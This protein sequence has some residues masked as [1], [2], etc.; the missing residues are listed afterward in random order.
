[1][2]TIAMHV[3]KI[4]LQVKSRE[5]WPEKSFYLDPYFVGCFWHVELSQCSGEAK[6]V[7][8]GIGSLHA[9]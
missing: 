9:G 6:S 7:T 1:M 4:C 8:A 3:Q 5:F 2:P